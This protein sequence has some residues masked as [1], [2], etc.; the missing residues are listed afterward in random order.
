[1]KRSRETLAFTARSPEEMREIGAKLGRA[2]SPG[3]LIALVGD[4]GAGKTT[5]AQ[6]IGMGVGLPANSVTSPTFTLVAEHLGGRLPLTHMDAYRLTNSTELHHLGFE[7]Y[8]RQ[9]DGLIVIEWADRI[10]DG[11][12]ADRL[13]I[14]LSEA[15]GIADHRLV[16]LRA[17]GTT[18]ERLLDM[19]A[20]QESHS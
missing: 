3:D 9:A 15:P 12:P 16:A 2:A 1:M 4:L 19:L 6:G 17:G 20:E 10:A 13:E 8:L 7:D 18:S 11:L 5:L 14:V